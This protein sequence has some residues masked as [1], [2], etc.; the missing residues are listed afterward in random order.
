MR[1]LSSRKSEDTMTDTD[2]CLDTD[3]AAHIEVEV[4][5]AEVALILTTVGGAAPV[6]L[7]GAAVLWFLSRYL[8][9]KAKP[10][11]KV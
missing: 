1:R 2:E 4:D 9:R 8:K 5:P 10:A 7:I 3:T 11:P 6:A